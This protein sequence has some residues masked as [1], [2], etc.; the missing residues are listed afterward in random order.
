MYHE[1]ATDPKVQMLNE[2]DQR[3]YVM[4]LCLKCC[5]GDVTLHETEVAFQLRVTVDELR[6]T[7]QRLMD[8]GLIDDAYIP[9]AWDKRQYASD[10]SAARVA[11][12]RDKKK[13]FGNVTETKCNVL[14]TDTDTDTDIKEI[15]KKRNRFVP[16]T[17][18][19][20]EARCREMGYTV[21]PDRFVNH[22][23]SNGW[24]VGKNKMKDWHKA[25]AGWQSRD[26]ERQK[27]T[28][29]D[30]TLAD[31]LNDTSWAH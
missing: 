6:E 2:V 18:E 21:N 25:L 24:M 12:H 15:G 10:S 16:P 17:V 30:R 1:F 20:V 28:T 7:K 29:R 5:N 23:G 13:R 4:L 27:D 14:D 22:Y 26:R 9:T 31:D 3:R 8:K 11:R 19:E